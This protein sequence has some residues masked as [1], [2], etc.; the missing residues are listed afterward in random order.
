MDQKEATMSSSTIKHPVARNAELTP[1]SWLLL[2]ARSIRQGIAWID[3]RR[4]LRRDIRELRAL[5]D[6]ILRDIGLCRSEIE[7][8]ARH[9]RE[10]DR[11]RHR[12]RW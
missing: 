3:S 4:R 9:G 11:Y 6:H 1:D 2:S 10:F 12:L 7:Y 8:A 5:D